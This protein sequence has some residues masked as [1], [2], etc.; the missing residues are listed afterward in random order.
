[1]N[2][3]PIFILRLGVPVPTV[4]D[5]AAVKEIREDLNIMG[6]GT[7]VGVLSLLMTDKTP[8]EIKNIFAAAAEETEDTLPVVI[9]RADAP[10]AVTIDLGLENVADMIETFE[11][12]NGIKLFTEGKPQCTLTLD[13]LL[14][15]ISRTGMDSLTEAEVVRL[16]SLKY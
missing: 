4:G 2:E 14:D 12:V 8:E 5:M 16:K 9:F 13:E 15:K 6:T 3:S 10:D 7:P 1:M 11:Q